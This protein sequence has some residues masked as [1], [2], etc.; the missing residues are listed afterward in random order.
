MTTPTQQ[1]NDNINITVESQNQQNSDTTAKGLI[2]KSLSI[3]SGS[4]ILQLGV[5]FVC[6]GIMYVMMSGGVIKIFGF[7]FVDTRLDDCY[8][9]GHEYYSENYKYNSKNMEIPLNEEE[10]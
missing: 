8:D 6:I 10:R 4:K 1:N 3:L 7:E 5:M 9:P 2:D